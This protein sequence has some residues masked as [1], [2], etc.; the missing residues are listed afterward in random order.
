MPG[1]L[2]HIM[3]R[4]I[5]KESVFIDKEDKEQ[6]LQRL[7]INLVDGQGF[8]YAWVVMDNHLHLL[9]K[10]GK[11]G[12]SDIMRKLLTWYAQY[13]NRL[14]R[15]RGHLFENRYKSILCEEETY[16]LALIRYIHLNPV[17]AGIVGT[18]EELDEYLWSGHSAVMRNVSRSWMDIDYVLAQF[19]RKKRAAGGR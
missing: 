13:Y 1:A 2:H 7:G 12:I 14:H 15:R 4:G 5:N 11:R 3:V 10:S 17:R 19:G 8:V 6:L 16:L 9:I 18:M